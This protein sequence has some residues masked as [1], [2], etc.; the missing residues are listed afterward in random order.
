MHLHSLTPKEK[1]TRTGSFNDV[2]TCKILFK[3]ARDQN[4]PIPGP[5]LVTKAEEFA[6]KLN[7][8]G[9]KALSG[10]IENFNSRQEIS[11]K[12]VCG[13]GKSVDTQSNKMTAWQEKLSL[14]LSHNPPQDIFNADET[15]IL[16]HMLPDKI[17]DDVDCYGGKKNKEKLT[18]MTCSNM[19]GRDKLPLLVIDK[20]ANSRCFKKVQ[21]LLVQYNAKIKAWKTSEIFISRMNSTRR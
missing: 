19:D 3:G 1:H 18:A 21:S 9:F 15:G 10:W 14:L 4:I 2:K 17:L 5:M 16:V 20:A 7:V 13:K 11:F 12:R 6:Q 8:T